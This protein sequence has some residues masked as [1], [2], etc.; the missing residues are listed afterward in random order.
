MTLLEMQISKLS[1][2]L[3]SV[4]HEEAERLYTAQKLTGFVDL[5]TAFDQNAPADPA[6]DLS[7][8]YRGRLGNARGHSQDGPKMQA[9]KHQRRSRN[10]ET[11]SDEQSRC[12]A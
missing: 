11:K 9:P 12:R 1:L 4:K 5:G 6:T 2:E 7:I 8:G 10:G 3:S